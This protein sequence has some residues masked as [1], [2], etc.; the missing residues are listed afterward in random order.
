MSI[1]F[2]DPDDRALIERAASLFA[3]DVS[4]FV[5]KEMKRLAEKV[6]EKHE[7]KCVRCGSRRAA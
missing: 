6:I 7:G 1:Y 4:P 3:M 5:A 2:N